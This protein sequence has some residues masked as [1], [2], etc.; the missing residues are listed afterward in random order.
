MLIKQTCYSYKI[1]ASIILGLFI[2]L[3]LN[4][5]YHFPFLHADFSIEDSEDSQMVI[6]KF[7]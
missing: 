1:A 3:V 4:V 2:F 5:V 6:Y 7:R